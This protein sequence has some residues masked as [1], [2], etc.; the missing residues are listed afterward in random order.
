[1]HA[2]LIRFESLVFC[3][4]EQFEDGRRARMHELSTCHPLEENIN[5]FSG[6]VDYAADKRGE[7]KRQNL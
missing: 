1:M 3:R 5:S 6:G 7:R 2:L 4:L